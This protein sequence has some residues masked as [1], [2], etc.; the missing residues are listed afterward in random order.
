MRDRYSEIYASFRWNVP[1]DFNIAHWTCRRWAGNRSRVALL[2]EDE[3]GRR[4]TWTYWDLLQAANRLS[5]ALRALGVDRGDRVALILPQRPQTVVAYLACFQ[6]GAVAVPLSF[7]FGP[8]ALE[9]RLADSN[10]K[11]AIV[12]S[13]TLAHLSPIRERLAQLRHVVGMEGAR[14]DGVLDWDATLASAS[15]QFDAVATR[16]DDPAAIIY[17]SGTTGPP[18]GALLAHSALIGNLPGFEHS[19]DGFPREGDLFW[20]PADWAWTGGLWDALMPTLYHGQVILGFLGRFEPERAFHMIEKYNVRNAFLFPTALKLMMRAFPEPRGRFDVRL[21]SLMSGGEALSPAVLEWAR[22]QLDTTVNEIFGQTEMNYI[23]GNSHALWPVKP[24]SMGRPY[25]GH[26][27][28]V[29]DDEGRPVPQG[30]VGDV[31]LRRTWTDG[32]PD[33][34]FFLGYWGKPEATAEKYAGD[35]CRTGDQASAD[36]DGYL[37]YQGRADDLF[38]V[39]GYRVGPTEIE[40]CLVKHPAVGNCAVVPTPDETRGTVVKAFVMLAPGHV[41]S[42]ALK[43]SIREHVKSHLAPYQQPRE[44]E[45]VAELPMTTTGKVQRKVLREL[46]AKRKETRGQTPVS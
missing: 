25:P 32:T 36:D 5:N 30:E 45:F 13:T 35:W 8:E 2:W 24:G 28:A 41:A 15:S 31:A 11:V 4:E 1:P 7:L 23:V 6:M 10:A 3:S 43:D 19:H 37:W 42:E 20:S 33:P 16:H 40:S 9:Y 17:T 26:L 38:K 27:V 44:I 39:A 12:D 22:E 46:E 29:I 14:G 18:K 34:V 21:R